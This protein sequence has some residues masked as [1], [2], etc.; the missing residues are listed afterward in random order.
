MEGLLA[1]RTDLD[2]GRA[3]GGDEA[4]GARRRRRRRRP[5]AAEAVPTR[6][7]MAKERIQEEGRQMRACECGASRKA[8]AASPV[9]LRTLW[10]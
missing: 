9:R 4:V 7:A 10:R 6:A 1:R 5:A 8:R 3:V 2:Y